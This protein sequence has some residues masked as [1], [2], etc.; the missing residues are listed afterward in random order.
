[1]ALVFDLGFLE[2]FLEILFFIFCVEAVALVGV[3]RW[4]SCV[5]S[6]T[7]L[8]QQNCCLCMRHLHEL[9]KGVDE[10]DIIKNR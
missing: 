5:A 6:S 1:M 10:P 8:H 3:W 4:L 2:P 9:G 7:N